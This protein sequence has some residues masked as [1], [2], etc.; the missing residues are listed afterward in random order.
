MMCMIVPL[1]IKYT[2]LIQ[3]VDAHL[4][5]SMDDT[6]VVE[7]HADM[8]DMTFFIA[9]KGQIS[10]LDLGQEIHQFAFFDLLRGVSG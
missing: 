1:L 4:A 8:D 5:G 7:H 3:I 6:L 2:G 9:E 10:W